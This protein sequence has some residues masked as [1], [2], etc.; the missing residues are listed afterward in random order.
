M[1][2]VDAIYISLMRRQPLCFA[3]RRKLQSGNYDFQLVKASSLP[4][5]LIELLTL[6]DGVCPDFVDR[7]DSLDNERINKSAHRTLRYFDAQH[8]P[9]WRLCLPST[10][11]RNEARAIAALACDAAR[12]GQRSINLSLQQALED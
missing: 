8:A 3:V 11:G 4:E 5:L 10:I 6:L 12:V 7:L 1:P 9:Q 2:A